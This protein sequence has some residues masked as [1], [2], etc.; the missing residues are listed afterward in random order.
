MEWFIQGKKYFLAARYATSVVS[1]PGCSSEKRWNPMIEQGVF[2]REVVFA[3]NLKPDRLH[4]DPRLQ[5][6]AAISGHLVW[7]DLVKRRFEK[8]AL[9][10]FGLIKIRRERL[11]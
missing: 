1:D 10:W 5:A 9:V 8:L 4:I 6:P 11:V 2:F 7:L 3:Q